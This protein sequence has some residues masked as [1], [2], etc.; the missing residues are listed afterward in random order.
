MQESKK[1]IVEYIWIDNNNNVRSKARTLENNVTSIYT[2]P[3][4]NYDGSST[5][6]DD[7]KNTEVVLKPCAIYNCPFRKGDNKLV[8]CCTYTNDDE[9][10]NTNT[11]HNA[12]LLFEKDLSSEPWFGI[13]Q[14]YFIFDKK[15]NKPLGFPESGFP[16]PQGPYYCG[17]GSNNAFGRNI[18]DEHYAACLY[19]GLNISGINAEVAPGQWEYQIGPCTGIKSGDQLWI[20]RYILHRI[21]EKHNREYFIFWMLLKNYQKLIVNICQYMEIIIKNV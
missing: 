19:A 15:T 11:R 7:G 5:G 6:Q 10:L 4:W 1:T 14:E 8:L 3:L 17:V 2:V 13:E 21:A 18:A 12:K 9:P 20:S 16:K